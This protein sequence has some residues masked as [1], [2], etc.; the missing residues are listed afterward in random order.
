M[1]SIAA[2]LPRRRSWRR[3]AAGLGLV[4]VS[5]K[6]ALPVLALG[7][8][9][10]LV[11][12]AN[13]NL[14]EG[15]FHVGVSE[16]ASSA[17]DKF[18][19]VNAR[20]EG[21]DSKDRPFSITADQANEIDSAAGLIALKQLQADITLESGTWLALRA[22]GGMF[23]RK[24]DLLELEGGVSLFHDR[25]Y[26]IEAKSLRVDLEQR[27]A[28]SHEPIVLQGPEGNLTAEGFRL[29]DGGDKVEF[30]GRSK[31]VFYSGAR[32]PDLAI[33]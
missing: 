21:I 14:S 10:L 1:P 20:F 8:I 3:R 19:L 28:S 4:G 7:L 12:W 29:L 18:N 15:R 30:F 13:S 31:L 9:G 16:L 23:R 32:A 11:F 33:E 2:A 17:A 25:G 6:L 24:S 26:A 27:V 5:L 22:D